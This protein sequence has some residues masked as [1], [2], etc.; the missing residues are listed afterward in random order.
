MRPVYLLPK[1]L[2]LPTCNRIK[3]KICILTHSFPRFEGDTATPFMGNLVTAMG[4][5]GHDVYV[6]TPFDPLLVL[7]N[8][9][10]FS[11][12]PYKYIFPDSL[13]I[14]GYA[15]TFKK[16]KGLSLFTYVIAP[17]MYFFALIALIKLVRKE[18]IDVV[19]AHWIIPNG[20]I[21]QL[22]K[23]ILNVPVV[24]S[25]P[26]ADVHM[27][28][29]NELFRRMVGISARGANHIVSDST[30]YIDQLKELGFSPKYVSILRYGVNP[31]TF[32]PTAKDK[33]IL[34][35]MG[36]DEREKIILAVG[37][38]IAQKG[39]IYLVRAFA[40]V[41]KKV[42][43]ATLV[44]IGDGYEM[45]HLVKETKKLNLSDRVIFPGTISYDQL[46]RYYNIADV[47]AMP[48]IKDSE[49]NLDA[50]PVAMMEAMACGVPVVATKFSGNDDLVIAGKTG[51]LVKEK[52]SIEIAQALVKLLKNKNRAE[53][54]KQVRAIALQHFSVKEIAKKYVQIFQSIS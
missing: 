28:G 33:T 2:V 9:G 10:P 44:M 49:G 37:R 50:S 35:H 17:F 52:N 46:S 14:L 36:V 25:I 12:I 51:F 30:H 5:L 48:S 6:L 32:Q 29:E 38:M 15:R 20:F 42:P 1:E 47:L 11:I 22:A 39:F 23:F 24:V 8:R 43:N 19:N 13:H 3:M 31:D 16:G 41:A 45:P 4:S 26:G 53:T 40:T 54:Q 21:A 27:G 18:N 34:T 7:R